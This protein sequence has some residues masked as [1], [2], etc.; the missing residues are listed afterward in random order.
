MTND[1]ID[2][3]THRFTGRGIELRAA[4]IHPWQAAEAG[5]TE[6][7]APAM[8]AEA[9]A[10]GETGLDFACDVDRNAQERL[11]RR[12]LDFAVQLR[13]PVVIHCVRAFEP[14]MKILAEYSPA[15]VVFHGFTGSVQMAER[16]VAE[17]YCLSFGIMTPRSPKTVAALRSVPENRLFAETDDSGAAIED[18]YAMIAR[19]RSMDMESLKR[20]ITENYKR[21]F[22]NDRQRLLG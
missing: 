16:A 17:G 6:R 12:H 7:L 4:G 8:F 1:F 21:I 14:T 3:H 22:D 10:V 5:A 9:Q 18:V 2:I 20:T 15:A 11:F 19:T 13:L